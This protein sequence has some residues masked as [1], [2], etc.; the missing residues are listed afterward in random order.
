MEEL[1]WMNSNINP[2]NL[3]SKNSTN[4][5]E[6]GL[7]DLMN[8]YQQKISILNEEINQLKEDVIHRDQDLTQLRIQYKILKQRSRSVDRNSNSTTNN[9]SNDDGGKENNNR[10]RRGFSVDGGGHLREQLDTSLDEI[11]LLKNKLL[12][13]EDELNNSALEKETLLVKLDEQSKKTIDQSINDDLHLFT[14]KIGKYNE[15]FFVYLSILCILDDLIILIKENKTDE[16]LINDLQ[17]ILRSS[18]WN[19]TIPVRD[20]SHSLSRE[21][22]TYAC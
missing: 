12:R 8:S 17:Q 5:N 22:E 6:N 18:R 21:R 1:A 3:H 2:K 4:S 16:G 7:S 15:N 10:A 11:R 14:Q 9:H 20:Q 13:L 19:K